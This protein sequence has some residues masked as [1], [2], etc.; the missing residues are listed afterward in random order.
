LYSTNLSGKTAFVT[1]GNG[2]LGRQF[3]ETL[4]NA[5]ATAISLDIAS[6]GNIDVTNE[7]DLRRMLDFV[8]SVDILINAAAN[9]PKVERGSRFSNFEQFPA[10]QFEDDLRVQLLGSLLTTQI[11]GGWMAANGGGVILNIASE[12]ALIGPDQRIYHD[13][14]KPVSYSVAKAGL[15][16]LTRYTATYWAHKNVRCN[17]LCPGGVQTQNMDPRFVHRVTERIPMGRMARE[18]EYNEAMLFLVSDASSY[19][20]GSIIS[21]DGGR[22]AW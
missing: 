22:T 3:C 10:Q 18:D 11:F 1:G 13:G 5:G 16:G 7:A 21:M 12:L 20:T 14:P 2:M 6:H 17:A 4:R 9:N 19:M 15:I 8:G